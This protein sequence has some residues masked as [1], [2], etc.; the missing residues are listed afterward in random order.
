[1]PVTN[2][3]EL[4]VA[5]EILLLVH[6]PVPP[7]RTTELALYVAV[8]PSHIGVDPVTD[9]MLAFGITV[10]VVGPEVTVPQGK[11]V[12]EQVITADAVKLPGAYV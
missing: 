10:I 3:D 9:A 8:A 5:T 11:F 1:M 12:I 2:P 6:E 7:L 4:T